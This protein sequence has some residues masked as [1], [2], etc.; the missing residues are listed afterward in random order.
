MRILTW[1]GREGVHRTVRTHLSVDTRFE[2]NLKDFAVRVV[3]ER[4]RSRE[5]FGGVIGHRVRL[6]G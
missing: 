5:I 3:P 4:D 1:S 6:I 2:T